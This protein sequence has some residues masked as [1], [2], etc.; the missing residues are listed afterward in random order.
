M[1][2]SPIPALAALALLGAAAPLPAQA[3]AGSSSPVRAKES[4]EAAFARQNLKQVLDAVND[5][6]FGAAYAGL[7]AVDLQGTLTIQLSAA[8]VQARLDQA[9]KGLLKGDPGSGATV[10]LNL[11]GTYFANADFRTEITGDFGH[12]LYYRVGDRGFLYSKE[13]NAWTSRVDPP[14]TEAPSSFLG[15]FRQCLNDVQA[16][17]V[18][19]T[20]FKARLG[21]AAGSLQ[22]LTFSSPTRGY[23]ARQREQSVA[24][25]LGFWKHGQLELRF[26]KSDRLPRQMHFSNENQ[27][28][29]T[30]ASFS[31]NPDGR[32]SQVVLVN[33]SKGMEGPATLSLGYG[34]GGLIDHLGG[35]MAFSKG[36]LRFDLDCAFARDRKVASIV[37][38]P[39]PTAVKKGREELETL[40]MVGLAGKLLDLQ[41]SGFNLRSVAV[42][43]KG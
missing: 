42:G 33:Q 15:W 3:A 35:Q 38:V 36:T 7:N 18:D 20:S 39:P 2:F 25:S 43:A 29:S 5:Q 27:G 14:P 23:D 10:R 32:L 40:L 12:L 4:G 30:Q 41:H 11:K 26:D 6:W 37:T 34:G 22:T 13:Q 1:T 24:A 28:V 8:A 17:Y 16:V 21:Q 9:G 19:G 31:H